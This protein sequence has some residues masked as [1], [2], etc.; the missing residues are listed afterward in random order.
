M[1]QA[2][3]FY[4][5]RHAAAE[6]LLLGILDE[7][8][9]RNGT[10]QRFADR[11]LQQTSSRLFDWVDHLLLRDSPLLHRQLTD[12]G[13]VVQEDTEPAAFYHPGALLP[14]SVLIRGVCDAEA[15]VALQVECVDDFLRANDFSATIEG[16]SSA[17]Y[18]RAVLGVEGGIALLAVAR[19]ACRDFQPQ[20]LT[21]TELRHYSAA[22]EL[23]QG[24][25]RNSADEA[26]AWT[27]TLRIAERLTAQLG[28]DLAAHV[29][30]QGERNY[31]Q[32]RNLA[33]RLQKSRQ[34]AMGLGWANHDHHAFRSSRRNFGRLVALFS[35][36]GF[37]CRERFYAGR[38]AGWGAQ[39]MENPVAGLSL[40]LDVDL[41]PEEVATDFSREELPEQDKLGTI[42]LWC[43]LHGDSIFEAG[44]HHLAAR[45]DFQRLDADLA[46]EGAEF[47]APF[48]DFPYLKQAFSVAERWPPEPAKVEKLVGEGRITTEQ[49]EK[50]LAQ[51]A[52]GSHL[53]NIE[54]REGY[55]GFNKK[56]VSAIILET[57]PRK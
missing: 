53:E 54:R 44:L 56:N 19:R 23:W 37:H 8:K 26:A 21:D 16:S 3:E 40:F 11:L 14:R 7:F 47:M 42:G 17:G 49:G 9:G 12:L 48:S 31:W 50:F 4:W 43:A 6:Q 18:R 24:R 20:S 35:L 45:C 57:D 32:E 34:D 27:E 46:R 13:F 36:L 51:G 25:P 15:G 33:G 52:V 1:A 38:E 29:V 2:Q 39:V 55:K 5:Q 22:L 28:A 41:A 10:L 30:C